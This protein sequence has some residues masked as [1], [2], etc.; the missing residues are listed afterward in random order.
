M[1]INLFIFICQIAIL[2]F[3]AYIFINFKYQESFIFNS[4]ID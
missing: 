2:Y 3:Q 1:T 4:I